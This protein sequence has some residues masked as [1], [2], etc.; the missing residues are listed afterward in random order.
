MASQSV[1]A[2]SRRSFPALSAFPMFLM[3]PVAGHAFQSFPTFL[4]AGHAFQKTPWGTS[5]LA[6]GAASSGSKD[7]RSDRREVE[8]EA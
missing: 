4:A 5:L 1:D 3:F 7:S 2:V 6:N 8:Q